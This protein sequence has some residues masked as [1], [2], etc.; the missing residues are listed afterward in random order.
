MNYKVYYS[1]PKNFR[2]DIEVASC[3]CFYNQKLL[4]VKR[5]PNKP[6]GNTW[7][8]P[9]GKIHPQET[10]K[11]CVIREVYEE[12]GIIISS[13]NFQKV[14]LLHL[15]IDQLRYNYHMFFYLLPM[16]PSI[17]LALEEHLEYRWSTLQEAYTLPLIPGGKECLDYFLQ[18]LKTQNIF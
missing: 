17:H 10:A 16:L 12:V 4:L 15:D 7:G 1:K 18:F 9:A 2:C 14:G 6:Y 8:V 5:H 13:V 3:Y 11:D